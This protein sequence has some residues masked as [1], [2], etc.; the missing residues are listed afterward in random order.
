MIDV[1]HFKKY[2]D[3]YGHLKGDECLVA[4]AKEIKQNTRKPRDVV[5]RFGGEEFIM[6]LPETD[7][8]G[9]VFVAKTLIEAIENLNIAHQSSPISKRATL[10]IGLAS[11]VPNE[12]MNMD[13]FLKMADDALYEAKNDGRNCFKIYNLDM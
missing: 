13:I 8:N 2:N 11:I 1:D 9:A 5:S 7:I 6:I 12:N 4:I 3:T 10:S